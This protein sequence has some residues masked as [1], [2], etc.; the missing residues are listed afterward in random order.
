MSET[1]KKGII[2]RFQVCLKARFPTRASLDKYVQ[3]TSK[4]L[5]AVYDKNGVYV[6]R[7]ESIY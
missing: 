3:Y 4:D 5:G 2:K 6:S 7:R 1:S